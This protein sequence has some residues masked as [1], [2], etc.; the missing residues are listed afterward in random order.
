[1][2]ERLERILV[3]EDE[4]DIQAVLQ[5]S[6]EDLGGYQVDLCDS[7]TEAL[8]SASTSR[9]DLILL[10]VMMPDLDGPATLQALRT[11]PALTR[12]PVIFITAQ[13]RR[14]PPDDLRDPHVLGVIEK[15]FQPRRLLAQIAELWGLQEPEIVPD[16]DR[17]RIVAI[18]HH[19]V[20]SLPRRIEHIDGLWAARTQASLVA[21]YRQAHQIS[22]TG[23]TL[24]L[25]QISAAAQQVEDLV[26]NLCPDGLTDPLLIE[27]LTPEI[28]ARMTATLEMLRQAVQASPKT[29][30]L[31]TDDRS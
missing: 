29:T 11:I 21:L 31:R 25:D 5:M 27:A 15:P 12:T 3:V 4:E 24:G 13:K 8:A 14:M 6:L 28:V 2:I 17:D 23:A 7:G 9:P 30:M 1:M 22:G 19:Y 10:D 20:S 16:L 26:A 18:Q